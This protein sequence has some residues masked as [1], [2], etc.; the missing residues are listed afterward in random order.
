MAI[1]RPKLP[2]WATKERVAEVK[3]IAAEATAEYKAAAEKA[4]IERQAAERMQQCGYLKGEHVVCKPKCGLWFGHGE[5]G[6]E[7]CLTWEFKTGD[8]GVLSASR[9]RLVCLD[10]FRTISLMDAAQVLIRHLRASQG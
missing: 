2:D 3:K 9:R 8:Y 1:E 5:G 7:K 4:E 10:K 6:K